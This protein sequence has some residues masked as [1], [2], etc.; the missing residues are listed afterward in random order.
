MDRLRQLLEVKRR[1][2]AKLLPSA[3]LLRAAALQRDDFRNFAWAIDRGPE[4]LG[5]I[6]EVK[7]ASPSAGAI[8]DAFDPV[9]IASAYAAAGAHAVSVL[10]DREFFQGDLSHLVKV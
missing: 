5:L 1:E 6:A 3:E 8:V 7:K 4:A 2:I 10:T 9:A